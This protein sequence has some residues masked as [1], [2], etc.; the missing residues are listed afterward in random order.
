MLFR[1]SSPIDWHAYRRAIQ[2]NKSDGFQVPGYLSVSPARSA[3]TWLFEEFRLTRGLRVADVKETNYFSHGWLAGPYSRNFANL[4][5]S[6]VVGDISPVY[7]LLPR[8]AIEQIAQVHP[9]VRILIVLREPVERVWSHLLF[10][11][12]RDS[13]FH[14]PRSDIGAIPESVL[15]PLITFYDSLCRYD[16]LARHWLDNH[17]RDRIHIEWFDSIA[18]APDAALD[19]ILGFLGVSD[20]PRVIRERVNAL[21]STAFPMP[22]RVAAYLHELY[23]YRM[24]D[25]GELLRSRAGMEMPASW[26]RQMPPVALD[27]L[28]ILKDFYGYDIYYHAGAYHRVPAGGVLSSAVV[29]ANGF[30]EVLP[31]EGFH[32]ESVLERLMYWHMVQHAKSL[33]ASDVPHGVSSLVLQPV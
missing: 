10:D 2:P 19:N 30:F 12:M 11:L 1:S 32:Y 23:A 13:C 20:H 33:P 25:L 24:A 3:T 8:R 14:V 6:E 9:K 5:P 29:S 15:L 17:P 26:H 21:N 4:S 18:A 27:P 22:P 16:V 28:A 7:A 31:F